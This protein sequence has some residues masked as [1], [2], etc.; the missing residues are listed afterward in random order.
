MMANN[1]TQQ[2]TKSPEEARIPDFGNLSTS[3]IYFNWIYMLNHRLVR[4]FLWMVPILV[5]SL[6]CNAATQM[7][8]PNTTTTH[9][10]IPPT[11][12]LPAATQLPALPPSTST[13]VF[14]PACPALLPEILRAASS[15]EITPSLLVRF[16]GEQNISYLV[17]YGLSADRLW[18]REDLIIPSDLDPDLDSRASHEF[19]WDYFAS[20]IPVEERS[21]VTEFSILSDG[22]H[23][24]LG[25][26]SPTYNDPSE[27]TLKMDIVDAGDPYSLSYTLLHE[28][29]HFLTLK[30]SQVTPD[31]QVFYNPD[32]QAIYEQAQAACPRYFTGEGCSHSG[33]YIN[34]FFNRFWTSFYEEWREVNE[35]RGEGPYRDMLDDFYNI[36]KDQFLTDYAATSPEEDIAE[37]WVYFILS[38]RPELTSIAN[39]KILFFYEYPELVALRE[40]ILTRLC[41]SF[42]SH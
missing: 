40:E 20:L 1:L 21:F 37:S 11:T 33:S 38:P 28:F 16:S 23:N 39:E 8:S 2:I 24:I 17:V 42:P 25:G 12:L 31:H 13:A 19:I 15:N 29:G 3:V 34:E 4:S 41:V 7:I 27:W 10:T 22:S 18:V 26:V 32:D 14:Q 6:A 5:S 35:Y 9:P 36:Y 30:S